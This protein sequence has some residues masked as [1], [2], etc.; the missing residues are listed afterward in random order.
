MSCGQR[1]LRSTH[2]GRGK[3]L[4]GGGELDGILEEDAAPELVLLPHKRVDPRLADGEDLDRLIGGG[5][6]VVLGRGP[7]RNVVEVGDRPRLVRDDVESVVLPV[8]EVSRNSGGAQVLKD[9]KA[10]LVR[11]H[12]REARGPRIPRPP[13]LFEAEEAHVGARG[14]EALE[15]KEDDEDEAEGRAEVAPGEAVRHGERVSG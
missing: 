9:G 10:R 12:A 5:H 13:R 14:D 4:G 11:E 1:A 6:A 15:R 8:S 7:D 2:E 3:V